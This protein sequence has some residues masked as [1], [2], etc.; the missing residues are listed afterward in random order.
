LLCCN[1][2]RK[3]VK[4]GRSIVYSCGK[5]INFFISVFQSPQV[6]VSLL[7]VQFHSH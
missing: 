4:E 3:Q 2:K 1:Q 5:N 7:G 6:F